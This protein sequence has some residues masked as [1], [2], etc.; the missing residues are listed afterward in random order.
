[1][2]I[3]PA[4]DPTASDLNTLL[5]NLVDC[6]AVGQAINNALEDQFGY[7]GGAS[8]WAAA[9]TGGLA[10]GASTLY[11]KIDSIDESALEFGLTGAA[12]AVDKNNDSMVDTIQTGKWNGTLTYGGSPAPLADATF[13]GSRM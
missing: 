5:A 9:C 8:T 12:K 10:Y 3:I 1:M 11:S 4:I 7:G 13:I 2:L 6:A